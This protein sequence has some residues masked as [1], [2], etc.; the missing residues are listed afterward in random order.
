M[1]TALAGSTELGGYMRVMTRPDFQGGDGQLGHWNLYGRLLNEGPWLSLDGRINVLE[2]P[3]GAPGDWALVHIRIEGGSVA[4]AD[5]GNGSLESLRL[6]QL[7]GQ[8][9]L[10]SAAPWTFQIG[11]I[12]SWWG[13]LGLYDMRPSTLFGGVVGGSARFQAGRVDLVVGAGDAGYAKKPEAY[14]TIF[15]GGSSLRLRDRKSTV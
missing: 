10:A 1:A 3:A 13:D 6:A 12:E 2:E 4:G 8:V 7:Y 9:G 14:N 11:S 15:T 5:A